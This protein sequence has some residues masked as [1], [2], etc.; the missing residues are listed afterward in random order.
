[1]GRDIIGLILQ[2][3]ILIFLGVNIFIQYELGKDDKDIF[4]LMKDHLNL[5]H[6]LNERI[7]DLE[8]RVSELEK[9]NVKEK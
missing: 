1:M 4:D 7:K 5:I 8:E 3:L 6:M 2:S 9:K